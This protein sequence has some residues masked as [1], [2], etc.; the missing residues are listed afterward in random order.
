ME[1]GQVDEIDLKP[2]V[3]IAPLP[4]AL[5]INGGLVLGA[6]GLA[7]AENIRLAKD[8]HVSTH[9]PVSVFF[10]NIRD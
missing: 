7:N 2:T 10:S 5:K 8:G 4:D 6:E 9:F 3:T 1:K